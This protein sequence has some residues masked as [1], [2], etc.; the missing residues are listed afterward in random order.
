[1]TAS[2]TA[3]ASDRIQHFRKATDALRE[4][5]AR[6]VV[7]QHEIVDDVLVALIAGGH[8]LLEG[9]PGLGKT[10]LVRTLASALALDFSR[11][12][13]TPDLMPS[14]ITGTRVA[15]QDDA[16]RT[17]LEFQ[18][19]PIFANIVLAD[20]INRATPRTQSAM[21]EAMQERSVTIGRVTHRLE[22]PFFV[23]ATQNP[24]EMDGT[25]T[26]PEAQLDRFLF[27][28]HVAFPTVA[29]LGAILDRTTAWQPPE[30]RPVLDRPQLLELRRLAAEVVLG[31]QNRD[32]AIRLVMATH[33]DRAEAPPLV[34]R[35]VRI[36]A[37]PRGAQALILAARVRAI[38]D[39]RPAVS[40][41]DIRASVKPALRHRLLRNFEGEA[42]NMSTDRVLEE[43]LANVKEAP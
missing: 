11:I 3:T 8:V 9:V 10:T 41:G 39:G 18:K 19:G 27:K 28:L 2:P 37:S 22:E 20:E 15:I 23:L 1:M 40:A 17:T 16:G 25:Y 33:P 43:V 34:R 13:F 38:L 30:V 32:Y 42:E 21:L 5:I 12:Q 24:L 26:L 7:G 29:D 36:G 6:V 31:P 4:A 14:D 35:F